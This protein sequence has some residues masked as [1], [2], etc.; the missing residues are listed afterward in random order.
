MPEVVH[1]DSPA[2]DILTDFKS[3]A[4]RLAKHDTLIKDAIEMMKDGNVKSLLIIDNNENIVGQ[5]AIRDLEGVKKA[6]AAQEHDIKPTEV[7]VGMLMTPFNKLPTLH[8]KYI[9]GN[10]VGHIARL[11]HDLGVFYIIVVDD[12]PEGEIVRGIFSI[13]R[14][15]RMLGYPVTGDLTSHSI[16]EM[17]KRF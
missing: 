7:T 1:L 4:P 11:F 10:R 12:S 6:Q 13:S 3:R 16:A 2:I 14:L 5:V 8:Y 17:N 9:S 15:S